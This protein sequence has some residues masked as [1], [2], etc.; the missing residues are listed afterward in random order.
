M[1]NLITMHPGTPDLYGNISVT[2]EQEAKL[3]HLIQHDRLPDVLRLGEHEIRRSEI[4][5][6]SDKPLHK[7]EDTQT[8]LGS[9]DATAA[10]VRQ[11]P[12]YYLHSAQS[13]P[14]SSEL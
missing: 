9:W 5:G 6:F 14:E 11:Q 4:L 7:P 8:R 3:T 12:W 13:L 1:R 10:W 2:E